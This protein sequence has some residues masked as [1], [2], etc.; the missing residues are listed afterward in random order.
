MGRIY[1]AM[2]KGSYATDSKAYVRL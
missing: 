1:Y 2:F